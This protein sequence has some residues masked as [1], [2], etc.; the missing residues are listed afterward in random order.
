MT[1]GS[2][3]KQ[4]RESHG[5]SQKELAEQ[6][7][8]SPATISGA[9]NERFIPSPEIWHRLAMTLGVPLYELVD[10]LPPLKIDALLEIIRLYRHLLH[11]DRALELIARARAEDN[12]LDYQR[13]ALQLEEGA[14]LIMDKD[15]RLQAIEML[16]ALAKKAESTAKP[17]SLFVMM[18]HNSIGNAW[19]LNK[20]Y[21]SAKYHYQRAI[22][23]LHAQPP[24]E[25]RIVPALYYNI[26]VCLSTQDQERLAIDYLNKALPLLEAYRLPYFTGSCYYTLGICYQ[27]LGDYEN[28]SRNYSLAI[29][30]Y[31]AAG[32]KRF[33]VRSR[34]YAAYHGIGDP[35]ETIAILE[36]ELILLKQELKPSETA[37]THARIAKLYLDLHDL[38]RAQARLDI[39]GHLITE[40]EQNEERGFCLLIRA[41]YLLAAG[42]Y[43]AAS[44]C[45][46]EAADLYA[47][48]RLFS[49]YLNEALQI[50]RTALLRLRESFGQK[51]GP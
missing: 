24:L 10:R 26:A 5:W 16:H 35:H 50:A 20:D 8:V 3:L 40:S 1:F 2:Y 47:S 44:T 37:V 25:D 22:D 51:K 48:M 12:L 42:E 19:F 38:P 11:R 41:K 18:V 34:S 29:P 46:I 13:D 15:T 32:N 7:N 49:L 43:E 31:E 23:L 17:D 4:H 21:V 45:A 27:H 14:I 36:E 9:E 28:S 33:A 6:V 39:A 30:Y